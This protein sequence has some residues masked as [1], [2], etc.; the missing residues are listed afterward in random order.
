VILAD[1]EKEY[2]SEC[3]GLL[4]RT[5]AEGVEDGG[6]CSGVAFLNSIALI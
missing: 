2:V 4:L 6:V 5:K 3:A 1:K